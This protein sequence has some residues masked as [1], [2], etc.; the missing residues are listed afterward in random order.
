MASYDLSLGE[1]AGVPIHVAFSRPKDCLAVLTQEKKIKVWELKTCI[2]SG[3]GK[4]LD[5]SEQ[6]VID[7][8]KELNSSDFRQ[9]CFW[10]KNSSP[11]VLRFACLAKLGNTDFL[12]NVEVAHTSEPEIEA[13]LLPEGRG[14]LVESSSG[15]YWQSPAGNIH[16]FSGKLEGSSYNVKSLSKFE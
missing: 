5:P 11:E 7:L 4:I 2:G 15:I 13:L 12:V 14:R 10:E 16:S 3:K 8:S 9:I 1:S 6:C